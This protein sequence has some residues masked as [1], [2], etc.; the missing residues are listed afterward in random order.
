MNKEEKI[1]FYK[2]KYKYGTPSHCISFNWGAKNRTCLLL[3]TKEDNGHLTFDFENEVYKKCILTENKECHLY[4]KGASY[5][6]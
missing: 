2:T 4:R 1:K 3:D 5:E 6:V